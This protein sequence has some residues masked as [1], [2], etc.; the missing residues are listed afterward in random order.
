MKDSEGL[1]ASCWVRY[2][3]RASSIGKSNSV[4][5]WTNLST[6]SFSTCSAGPIFS[7]QYSLFTNTI[8]SS[9]LAP[10]SGSAGQRIRRRFLQV[11][12]A[13]RRKNN[14]KFFLPNV[15]ASEG[16]LIDISYRAMWMN[17]FVKRIHQHCS[18]NTFIHIS[19]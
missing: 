2:L 19:S 9:K 7:L 18:A 8:G 6:L 1:R 4:R 16:S 3:R 15:S 17:V 13:E 5:M 11:A 10:S 14:H 12:R